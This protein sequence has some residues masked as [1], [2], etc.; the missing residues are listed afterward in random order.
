MARGSLSLPGSDGRPIH[1]VGHH[2]PPHLPHLLLLCLWCQ[3]GLCFLGQPSQPWVHIGSGAS[4][5]LCGVMWGWLTL[6][7]RV[8][9]A[10]LP[11]DLWPVLSLA[12]LPGQEVECSAPAGGLL[13]LQPRPGTSEACVGGAPGCSQPAWLTPSHSLWPCQCSFLG[14]TRG[15][16]LL[17]TVAMGRGCLQT[18]QVFPQVGD[19]PCFGSPAPWSL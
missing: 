5:E 18:V 3:V 9:Q 12:S 1:P 11:K 15:S 2:R 13:L 4:G 14:S 8:L 10:V 7:A 19:S 17:S 16:L 6:S